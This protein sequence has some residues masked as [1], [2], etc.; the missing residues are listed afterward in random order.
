[1]AMPDPSP[2][3]NRSDAPPP[4]SASHGKAW[5]DFAAAP[6]TPPAEPRPPKPSFF[7]DAVF[8]AEPTF[9]SEP[10]RD[11]DK[12]SSA[13]EPSGTDQG[14]KGFRDVVAEADD[15]GDAAAHASKSVRDTFAAFPPAS[16]NA[17]RFEPR[18]DQEESARKPMEW[19]SVKSDEP[20]RGPSKPRSSPVASRPIA[21][22]F[23][24]PRRS[25]RVGGGFGGMGR[26]LIVAGLVLVLGI[27]A[28]FAYRERASIAGVFQSWRDPATQVSRDTSQARPKISDRIGGQQDSSARPGSPVAPVAQ[29]V[30]LYEQPPNVPDRKQYIGSVIWRAE[31]VSPGPGLPPDLAI[32]ADVEIPERNLRMSFTLRRNTE[33]TLPASHTIEVLFSTP[34]DFPLGAVTDVPGILMD[35]AEQSRG[36]PLTGLRVKVAEGFFLIGLSAV[37]SDVRRNVELLKERS[38]LHGVRALM[39]LEKGVPGDRVFNDAFTAWK[40]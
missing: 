21:D 36:T 25:V 8:P 9:P 17:D 24:E 1:M 27:A 29:R 13:D 37:E 32:K 31:T 38:W 14:L 12:P 35:Q 23:E 5:P 16:G 28:V 20:P 11:Q 3:K 4:G 7:S 40:Q 34:P 18:F 6:S 39:A 30:V 26:K 10:G 22:D 33:Q 19:P 15:L 2:A